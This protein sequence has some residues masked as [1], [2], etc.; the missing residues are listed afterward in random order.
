[1]WRVMADLT[2]N[3][4]SVLLILLFIVCAMYNIRQSIS[5]GMS[6]RAV[7]QENGAKKPHFFA[8]PP[9]ISRHLSNPPRLSTSQIVSNTQGCCSTYSSTNCRWY[10]S[11]RVVLSGRVRLRMPFMVT[12]FAPSAPNAASVSLTCSRMSSTV[13]IFFSDYRRIQ[14]V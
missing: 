10:C 14:G 4:R 1:M 12:V 3:D 9:G 13:S 2:D 6:Y 7:P 5:H 8:E 11:G